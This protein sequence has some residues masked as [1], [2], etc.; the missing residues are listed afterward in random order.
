MDSSWA[1]SSIRS[2]GIIEQGQE[3]NVPWALEGQASCPADLSEPLVGSCYWLESVSA[4]PKEVK[5]SSYPHLWRLQDRS[6]G[7]VTISGKLKER[8]P[9]EERRMGGL[10]PG[11]ILPSLSTLVS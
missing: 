7:A 6:M 10:L 3:E 9:Q 11:E 5:G 2:C 1:Q 8:R 4:L